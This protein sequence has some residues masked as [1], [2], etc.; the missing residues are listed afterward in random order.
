MGKEAEKETGKERGTG[1][2]HVFLCHG[3]IYLLIFN[4]QINSVFSLRQCVS[5]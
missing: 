1:E 2:E 4:V 3:G 5:E